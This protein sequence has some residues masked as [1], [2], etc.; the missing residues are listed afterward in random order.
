MPEIKPTLLRLRV[1]T[2]ETLRQEVEYSAHRSMSALADDLLEKA[3]REHIKRRNE[4]ALEED[5]QRLAGSVC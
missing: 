3:L 2:S 1:S 5:V 4:T